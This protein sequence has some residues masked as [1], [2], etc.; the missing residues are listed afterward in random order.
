M[1]FDFKIYV[2]NYIKLSSKCMH[3]IKDLHK[4]VSVY[5]NNKNDNATIDPKKI[6]GKIKLDGGKGSKLP[7]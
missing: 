2:I 3:Q 4:G 7:S 5:M 1:L 6:N